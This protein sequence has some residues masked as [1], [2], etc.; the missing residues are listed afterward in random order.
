MIAAWLAARD[1]L[2][3]WRLSLCLA[4]GVA[5]AAAPLLILFSLRAGV[6]DGMRQ[7][8]AR[9]PSSRELRTLGQ[10][11]IPETV[12]ADLR[13]N[14]DVGFAAPTIRML[15]AG[16]V[17]RRSADG[18]GEAVDLVP[19]GPA[20]PL[21]ATVTARFG[22]IRSITVSELAARALRLRAGERA[23]LVVER[24]RRDGVRQAA[25]LVLRVTGVL[26]AY[27]AEQRIALVDPRVLAAVEIYREDPAA[28]GFGQALA[29]ARDRP[30]QNY[31]GLRIYAA[32]IDRV[33]ALRDWLMVRGI[34]TEGR[35][36]EIR[37]I[38][39]TSSALTLLFLMIA[40]VVGG[41][42]CVSLA[43]AQWA[44][45]ER[46]RRDLG[47][48]RL[49]GLEPLQVALLPTVQCLLTVTLGTT[50]AVAMAAACGLAVND[51]FAARLGDFGA[52]SRLGPVHIV[53]ALLLAVAGGGIASLLASRAAARVTPASV[54][55]EG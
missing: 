3:E 27:A 21:L 11:R 15:A 48:L 29:L 46:R 8:L 4:L 30:A 32:S 43:A 9:D 31:A 23:V 22:G 28:D 12:V 1:W 41:G 13:R 51:A 55:R 38:Q 35:L 19:S 45:V 26:P 44:W 42:L 54:L 25:R 2:V 7:Q 24:V 36:A 52:L 5:A 18:L 37:L 14:G 39:R 49:I 53:V 20:D 50:L 40:A 34:Q 47:Y 16:A 17:L 10:A 6:V 33:A